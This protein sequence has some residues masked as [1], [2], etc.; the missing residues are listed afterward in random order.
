MTQLLTLLSER[1][2]TALL[3]ALGDLLLLTFAMPGEPAWAGAGRRRSLLW[4]GA[5][6]L[7][8]ALAY[9]FQSSGY[10]Y[11]YAF[12]LALYLCYWLFLHTVRRLPA[13]TAAY[14][15]L[16][17]F[18]VSNCV[19]S[20]VRFVSMRLL[21]TD[22]LR[23]GNIPAKGAAIVFQVALLAGV[24]QALKGWL[25]G[26]SSPRMTRSVLWAAVLAAIPYLF[27]CQIT[28]WLPLE[29]EQLTY[30]IPITLVVTCALALTMQITVV[31]RLQAEIEKRQ[32]LQAQRLMEQRQQQFLLSKVSADALRRNYHDLKN[33]LLYLEQ[34]SNKEEIQAYARRV[35]G[36]IRP[37]ETLV[38]TG[39]ETMDI[40]LSEKLS[41]C[42][43]E[44]IACTIDVEGP[45]FDFVHPLELC[46][47]VGNGMDNAIEASL[48][49][50]EPGQR[51]ILVKSARRGDYALFS[52]RNNCLPSPDHSLRTTKPNPEGHGYGIS[53]I[54]RAA[55]AYGGEAA[56]Q[57]QD[58]SFLLTVLLLRP[59][60]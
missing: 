33:I 1:A 12:L 59:L 36:E 13:G 46:T 58:G 32:A 22:Y 60:S 9:C 43:A 42:Q 26:P 30:A 40:L 19:D 52:I 16:W 47:I 7:L 3:Q 5:C 38:Q 39:N 54:R 55:Q 15:A 57:Q 48:K 21:H 45:L 17:Y 44:Q 18:L 6:G 2:L 8:M 25:P 31:G 56:C 4:T 23:A 20:V 10:F 29:N 34:A 51:R 14:A 24:L 37:F 35:M 28:V 50:A 27:V 41:I 49:L 53:N 11:S